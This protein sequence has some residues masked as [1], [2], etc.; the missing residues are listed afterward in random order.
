[1]KTG[2]GLLTLAIA[3]FSYGL[4]IRDILRRATKPHA[5]SWLVWSILA[6]TIYNAQ[7]HAGAGAGAW[8][9]GF[10]C[11]ATFVIFLLAL[12]Y[13]EKNITRLDWACLASALAILLLRTVIQNDELSVVLA[14]IAFAVGFVPT[15]R[16]AY[17]RPDQETV[18][19][20]ALNGTKFFLSIT[21]L[22][23]F[24]RTTAIYP[25]SASALNFFFVVL[26]LMRRAQLGKHRKVRLAR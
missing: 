16:K 14:S 13:G 19:T 23:A 1:M 18:T 3:V 5:F 9:T 2:I 10:T 21:A 8:I 20:Y 25:A 24:T 7:I 17:S 4:Y 26:L 11:V 22:D 12:V 15:I 6:G